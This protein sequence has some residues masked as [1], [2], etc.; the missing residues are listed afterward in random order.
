M[1]RHK[2][3]LTA[4]L[5]PPAALPRLEACAAAAG[6]FLTQGNWLG[7]LLLHVVV[8]LDREH[9]PALLDAIT[10]D[11][12]LRLRG[13]PAEPPGERPDDELAVHLSVQIIHDGPEPRRIVPAVPG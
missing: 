8:E 9:W 2:L 1:I 11:E 7:G 3:G 6:G 4:H 13:V 5:A 12:Q 10:A